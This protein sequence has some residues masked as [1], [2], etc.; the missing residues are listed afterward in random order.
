MV[1]SSLSNIEALKN[2]NVLKGN[3]FNHMFSGCSSLTNIQALEN[4]KLSNGN[5]F[6]YFLMDVI[7][8]LI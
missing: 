6:S 4:W 7:H 3:N 1:C 5:D 2:W 8:Y